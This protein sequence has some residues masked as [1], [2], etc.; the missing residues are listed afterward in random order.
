M[1]DTDVRCNKRYGE[2]IGRKC[3]GRLINPVYLG[4]EDRVVEYTCEKC[5][6]TT[7]VT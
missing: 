7:E 2:G 6:E 1:Y 3:G 4:G 5:G